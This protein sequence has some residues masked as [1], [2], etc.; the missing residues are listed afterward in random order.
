MVNGT[1]LQEFNTDG[2]LF[3]ISFKAIKAG[4]ANIKVTFVGN[5]LSTVSSDATIAKTATVETVD[6][7]VKVEEG[8]TPAPVDGFKGQATICLLYTSDAADE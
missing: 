7:A 4:D 3:G 6:A 1:A 5:Q 8:S 2:N